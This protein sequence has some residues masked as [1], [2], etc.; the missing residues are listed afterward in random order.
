MKTDKELGALRVMEALSAVDQELLERCEESG[1]DADGGA[2]KAYI[3]RFV[4]RYAKVCAAC[5][6]LAVLGTAYLCMRQMRGN[7]TESNDGGAEDYFEQ[8]AGEAENAKT[9]DMAENGAAQAPAEA[10]EGFSYG[11]GSSAG[12]EP[13]WL[14]VESLLTQQQDSVTQQ[15]AEAEAQLQSTQ[16]PPVSD[17]VLENCF[18]AKEISAAGADVPERYRLVEE[19]F[20]NEN[21]EEQDSLLYEWTD[22]EHSLW[23]R[24]TQTELKADLQIDAEPPVYTVR[25]EW[26]E[27]IPDAGVDGYVQF[28]LL[29]EDGMLTEYC[30]VLEREEIIRLMESLTGKGEEADD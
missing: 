20:R 30:G 11:S 19:E 2:K 4:Q 28:A 22:G 5:L 25:Q 10:A 1:A 24:V 14:D 17:S 6:C 29:Y 7:F 16:K 23:L 13:E 21:R 26:R 18:N 27:L 3:H 8:M 12:A 15:A 9:Q